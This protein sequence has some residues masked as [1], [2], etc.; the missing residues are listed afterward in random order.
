MNVRQELN[1]TTTRLIALMIID[2]STIAMF[3]K[4][5]Q[6]RVFGF[7]YQRKI[8]GLTVTQF[9]TYSLVLA[10]SSAELTECRVESIVDGAFVPALNPLFRIS[11]S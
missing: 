7:Q 1:E 11:G 5:I 2:A 6:I 4:N 8:S 3:K 10:E 9:V